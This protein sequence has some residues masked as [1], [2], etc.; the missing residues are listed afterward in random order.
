VEGAEDQL[1]TFDPDAYDWDAFLASAAEEG[2]QEG[3]AA[4]GEADVDAPALLAND[5]APQTSSLAAVGSEG[6]ELAPP[7]TA[8]AAAAVVSAPVPA[9]LVAAAPAPA[10]E[11]V[12]VAV[13]VA[14]EKARGEKG[15]H[16][17][18]KEKGSKGKK[19]EKDKVHQQPPPPPQQQQQQQPHH[20]Q[21]A[22]QAEQGGGEGA[23][24]AKKQRWAFIFSFWA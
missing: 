14:A 15:K 17:E 12:A 20:H 23:R 22:E 11:A 8:I 9:E 5:N 18:K 10:E 6:M 13:V 4:D 2:G 19:R 3:A 7:A 16:R 1:A 24:P 21:Q